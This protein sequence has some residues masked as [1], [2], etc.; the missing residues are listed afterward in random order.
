MSEENHQDEDKR[1]EFVRIFCWY[2][3]E[4]NY[5]YN[6]KTVLRTPTW[7]EI[8]CEVGKLLAA[9]TFYDLDGSVSECECAIEDIRK[10][11]NN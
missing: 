11:I 3:R 2:E 4:S 10:Q 8:Y 9:R 1:Q 7:A 5:P 6:S